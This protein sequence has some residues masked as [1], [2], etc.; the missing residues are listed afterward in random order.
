MLEPMTEIKPDCW[1]IDQENYSFV[2]LTEAA[3]EAIS[4]SPDPLPVGSIITIWAGTSDRYKASDFVPDMRDELPNQAAGSDA[5]EWAEDWPDCTKEQSDE[6]QQAIEQLVDE[7][8]DRHGLQPSFYRVNNIREVKLRITS[9]TGAF[10]VVD[11]AKSPT[12]FV[13]AEDDGE[14]HG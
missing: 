6:L 4:R 14:T 1:S 5:G 13:L 10:D 8:A 3:E 2:D 7:W 9:E 11:D 12:V